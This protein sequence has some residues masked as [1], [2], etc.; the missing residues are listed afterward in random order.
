VHRRNASVTGA[1]DATRHGGAVPHALFDVAHHAFVEGARVTLWCRAMVW[2][3]C[4]GQA[5]DEV[6]TG[7]ALPARVALAPPAHP[8]SATVNGDAAK[9]N[10]P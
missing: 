1:G 5:G 3:R 8:G 4:R 7:A 2:C 6:V 10:A 9:H